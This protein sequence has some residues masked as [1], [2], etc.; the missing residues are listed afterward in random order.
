M[1]ITHIYHSC[2]AVEDEHT[3]VVFDYWKDPDG[4]LHH[5]IEDCQKEIF[6]FV[7]HFHEDHY[8]PEI[9]TLPG[10]KIIS[11]DTKKRRRVAD[12]QVAAVMRPDEQFSDPLLTATAF[13][14]T[15]VGLCYLVRMANGELVF[16]AGDYNNWYFDRGDEH[17][18]V[19]AK[20]MEGLF[21]ATL[22]KI[23][24]VAPTIDH[25]MFPVDPRL[26]NQTLRG[27]RQ[28]LQAIATRHFYPMHTWD[29][30]IAPLMAALSEEFP[31]TSFHSI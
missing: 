9:L 8:N 22:R 29:M 31:H 4:V 20:E 21:M 26:E 13:K 7:S 18:K 12:D 30:E 11:Y 6:F 24:A 15:D 10:K 2:F 5:M 23:K 27:P 17:L 25:A 19:S 1:T 14:S 28:W 3:L 16:H